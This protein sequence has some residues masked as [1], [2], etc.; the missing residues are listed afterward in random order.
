M[1]AKGNT[2][3]QTRWANEFRWELA[4]HSAGEELL[5]YPK[6]EKNLGVDGK[7]MA[8]EDRAQ[9]LEVSLPL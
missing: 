9:H 4:R 5:V 1:S 2:D 6:F 3:E 8:E 7:R